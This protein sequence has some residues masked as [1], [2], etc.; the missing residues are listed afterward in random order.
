MA[1]ELIPYKFLFIAS[2][3]SQFFDKFQIF[4]EASSESW[5][6]SWI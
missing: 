6:K 1:P 3:N 2:L 5:T 4:A